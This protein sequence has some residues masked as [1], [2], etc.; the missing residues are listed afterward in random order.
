MEDLN[1]GASAP[2]EISTVADD[3]QTPN[4]ISTEPNTAEPKPEPEAKKAPT[5]REAL[6]AA[7]EKVNE[8]AKAEETDTGKKPVEAQP[9]PGE[10]AADKTDKT[11]PDPKPTK[12]PNT[13]QQPAKT[14][15]T[16]KTEPGKPATQTS[17]AEAPARFKSD[18]AAMAEWEKAPDPVKAAV[19]RS[20]RELEAGIE[21]HRVPAEEF[22]K[23][24]DFH[25]LAT[26]NNTTMRDAMTRYTNL[27][28]TLLSDPLK[29]IEAVCDYAG[30]SLR[31]L[32]AHVMGQKPDEVQGQ[33]DA[34]IQQLKREIETLKHSVGGVTNTMQ[35]QHVA[36]IDAQVQKFAADNPRFEDLAEDI[37]FFLK[38]GKTA[39]LAEAYKLAEMLNPDP[40]ASTTTVSA[41]PQTRTAQ[42][43][44]AQTLKG[45]KSI[46]GAPSAGS[47]PA[48]K[49]AST[50]IKDSL[51]R[52]VAQAG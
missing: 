11:L 41:A 29:G 16:A 31:Q 9:K 12:D 4:P 8:K 33:N 23:V 32:A 50:S 35:Q 3:A 40:A 48:T 7:A 1:G 46:T 28:R 38:S 27:E 15:E 45:Q 17:H 5:A 22:E 21:K 39:D 44:Q 30:I 42:D 49:R 34:T 43:P 36:T 13:T 24:R 25:E 2:A 19:H 52:A 26:K 18:A 6:K 20:I 51:R 47:D 10:K 14:A 37:A